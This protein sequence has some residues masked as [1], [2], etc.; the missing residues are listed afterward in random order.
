MSEIDPNPS[1]TLAYAIVLVRTAQRTLLARRSS[2]APT[3][4]SDDCF[5]SKRL[6]EAPLPSAGSHAGRLDYRQIV[7]LPPIIQIRKA[8]TR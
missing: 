6:F 5:L 2:C 4:G 8:F 7:A 3:V 1:Y